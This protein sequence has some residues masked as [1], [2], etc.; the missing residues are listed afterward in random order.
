[1]A[2]Q[3]QGWLKGYTRYKAMHEVNMKLLL[4]LRRSGPCSA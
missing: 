4:H 1:M 2:A 3:V